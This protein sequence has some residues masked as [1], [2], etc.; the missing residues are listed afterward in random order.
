MAEETQKM[1]DTQKKTLPK[2]GTG[3]AEGR[4]TSGIKDME[5]DDEETEKDR[6]SRH[7]HSGAG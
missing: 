3:P 4:K 2:P 6:T 7:S 5:L 1:Q